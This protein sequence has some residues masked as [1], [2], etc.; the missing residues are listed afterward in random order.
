MAKWLN[1][2]EISDNTSNISAARN[3]Q[4]FLLQS[5][6]ILCLK[7][8]V[9]NDVVTTQWDMLGILLESAGIWSK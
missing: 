3:I 2:L 6:P 9:M 5:A 4:S 8:R 1:G 7:I